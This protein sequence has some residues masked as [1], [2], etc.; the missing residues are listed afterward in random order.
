MD[1]FC[2]NI[3]DIWC[4][5]SCV[6]IQYIPRSAILLPSTFPERKSRVKVQSYS[7]SFDHM[8]KYGSLHEALPWKSEI[9]FWEGKFWSLRRFN[10]SNYLK[11]DKDNLEG[12]GEMELKT[13]FK[14]MLLFIMLLCMFKLVL[15]LPSSLGLIWWL[16]FI[17]RWTGFLLT[18]LFTKGIDKR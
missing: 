5:S 4:K 15:C 11:H 14:L 8:T 17:I 18:F 10:N 12:L 2:K 9:A 16:F 6:S 3:H 1:I 13:I 7:T